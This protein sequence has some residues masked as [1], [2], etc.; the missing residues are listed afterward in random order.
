MTPANG[1]DDPDI[2]R[3]VP[4]GDT[5]HRTA[6]GLR[7][8]L[9]GAE[10]TSFQTPRRTNHGA[11]PRAGERVE[12]IE[13]RGKHLLIRFSGGMTLHTHMRMT[14][15]W[16]V[17]SSADRWR[18][19]A[20]QARVTLTC[21]DRV[22]VCFNAPVVEL[23]HEREVERH[24]RLRALGPDLCS[25]EV[26]LDDVV[27]RLA[28]TASSTPVGVALLDQRI[29]SGIGNVYKS[30]VLFAR[31]LDPFAPIS[32]LDAEQRRGV[33][34]T[35]GEMLRANLGSG[36]RVTAPGGLAVYGKAGRPCPRCGTPIAARRQG[37]AVRLT[38]FCPS[39]QTSAA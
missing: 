23:L 38:Y 30:E 4:E 24:P 20:S 14:G 39:C 36:P 12:R 21:G 28:S 17:Y 10:L 5:I 9:L 2:L 37:E 33:Y 31:R 8:A 11:S 6:A 1:A 27:R 16:H 15:A 34:A 3:A 19:P 26:D 13:A 25:P 18:R 7:R 35:A 22:A 32:S 29:A